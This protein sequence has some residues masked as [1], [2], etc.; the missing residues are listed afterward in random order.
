MNPPRERSVYSALS[1][2]N[3]Y[4]VLAGLCVIRVVRVVR[5][6]RVIRVIRAIGLLG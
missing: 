1:L 5:V 6:I 2:D 3:Y 4:I